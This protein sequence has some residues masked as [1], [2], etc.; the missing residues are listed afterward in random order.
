MDM[1][2]ALEKAA[3]ATTE[4]ARGVRPEQLTQPTPCSE[5]TVQALME[6]VTGT[7][8]LFTG[9]I[10][11]KPAPDSSDGPAAS[12][13]TAAGAVVQ[14]WKAPA[15]LEGTCQLPVGEMPRQVAAGI[16]LTDI[17]VHGWDLAKAT[18]QH[19]PAD[20]ELAAFV[21]AFARQ[22]VSPEIRQRGAFA[23]E[24]APPAGCSEVD[25]LA[26]FLGRRP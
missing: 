10:S 13:V 9:A 17:Y 3:Q 24:I 16:N 26:A 15:A 6:H 2:S 5:W 1:I 11:G 21:S 4:V 8:K 19:L 25:S 23:A 12:L 20:P 14:A 7:C 22:F 18:G